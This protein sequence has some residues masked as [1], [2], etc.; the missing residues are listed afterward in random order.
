MSDEGPKQVWRDGELPFPRR[1]LWY[2]A[3]KILLLAAIAYAL[4]HWK[5]LL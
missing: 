4:L 2:V 5:G 1:W 3:L